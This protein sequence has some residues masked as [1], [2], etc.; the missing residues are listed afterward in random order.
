MEMDI[1]NRNYNMEVSEEVYTYYVFTLGDDLYALE[2]DKIKEIKVGYHKQINYV[3]SMIPSMV[4][5]IDMGSGNVSFVDLRL[6]L[7]IKERQ[8]KSKSNTMIIVETILN[9]KRKKYGL[10]FDS[11]LTMTSVKFKDTVETFLFEPDIK[12]FFVSS[13]F[14]QDEELIKVLDVDAIIADIESLSKFP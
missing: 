11:F 4:G 8:K 3:F 5:F 10:I 6:K 2:A 12:P 9:E 7:K 13:N 1:T 14:S